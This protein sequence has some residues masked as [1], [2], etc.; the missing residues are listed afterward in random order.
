MKTG[1]L[2]YCVAVSIAL[3]GC[4][5]DKKP[6]DQGSVTP[7]TDSTSTVADPTPVAT[8]SVVPTPPETASPTPTPTPT[9]AIPQP[10]PTLGPGNRCREVETTDWAVSLR[11]GK[12]SVS[13]KAHLKTGGW[14]LAVVE[15]GQTSEAPKKQFFEL[16]ATKGGGADTAGPGIKPVSGSKTGVSGVNRAEIRCGAS[17]VVLLRL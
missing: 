10:V 15:R 3:V 16:V 12:I 9:V 6:D 5:G 11:E 7:A 17:R 14:K 4:N 8:P 1:N 2:L 13:G